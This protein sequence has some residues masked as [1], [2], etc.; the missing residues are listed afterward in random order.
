MF[1]SRSCFVHTAYFLPL[2]S[3][4]YSA[5]V[6]ILEAFKAVIA[7]IGLRVRIMAGFNFPGIICMVRSSWTCWRR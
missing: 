6:L 1:S 7:L 5:N 4:M 3:A 2:Y